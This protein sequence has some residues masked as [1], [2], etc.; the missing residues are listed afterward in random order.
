MSRKFTVGTE[1]AALILLSL[2]DHY[3]SLIEQGTPALLRRMRVH[4]FELEL[5]SRPQGLYIHELDRL[6][7]DSHPPDEELPR[8]LVRATLRA[9]AHRLEV[10]WF[11]ESDVDPFRRLAEIVA[12]LD[13]SALAVHAPLLD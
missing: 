2:E 10:V 5:A 3:A 1:Q 8:E 6:R 7:S 13:W 4:G 9:G 11:Q 12:P